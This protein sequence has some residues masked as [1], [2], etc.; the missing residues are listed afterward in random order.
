MKRILS[1]S[2]FTMLSVLAFAGTSFKNGK[3]VMMVSVEVKDYN[4]WKLGFDAGAPVREKAGIKVI[5]ICRAI[6]NANKVVVVEEA[7]NA[8]SA[9]DFLNLLKSKQK[10]GEISNIEVKLFDKVE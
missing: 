4:T 5:S 7:E 2:I 10:A 8:Q 1:I 6:D 9:H 3:V